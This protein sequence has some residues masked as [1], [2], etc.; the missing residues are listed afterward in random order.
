MNNLWQYIYNL[1]RVEKGIHAQLNKTNKRRNK[2][3]EKKTTNNKIFQKCV[4]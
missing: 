1:A 3:L 4:L 2:K